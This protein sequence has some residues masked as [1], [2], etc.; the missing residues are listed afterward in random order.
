[1]FGERYINEM[2]AIKRA[3]DPAGILNRGV[4]FDE[5]FL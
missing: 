3:F 4:M 2:A 1:M 5:K